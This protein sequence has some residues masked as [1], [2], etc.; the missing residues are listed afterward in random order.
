MQEGRT[1]DT[2]ILEW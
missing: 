2:S 1:V